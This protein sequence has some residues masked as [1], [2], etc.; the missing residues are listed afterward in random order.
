MNKEEFGFLTHMMLIK[1]PI[2][3]ISMEKTMHAVILLNKREETHPNV[4]NHT[5]NEST[6]AMQTF[7]GL[8]GSQPRQNCF[9]SVQAPTKGTRAQI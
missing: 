9:T 3:H 6:S 5:L 8:K 1:H 4:R 2:F 7:H